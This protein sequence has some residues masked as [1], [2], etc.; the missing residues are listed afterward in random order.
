M[1][2]RG[3]GGCG[4]GSS[5]RAPRDVGAAG[6][7][8]PV[9]QEALERLVDKRDDDEGPGALA[10]GGEEEK[11]APRRAERSIFGHHAGRCLRGGSWGGLGLRPR[12]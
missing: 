6:V 10:C 1:Q 5:R 7:H 2:K 11:K 12:L 9:E 3:R 4:S 8:D